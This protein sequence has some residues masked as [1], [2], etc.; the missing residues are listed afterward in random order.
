[1]NKPR[2][3]KLTDKDGKVFTLEY[4]R[5][6]AK[7]IEE[8]GLSLND[9]DDKPTTQLPLLFWGAFRMHHRNISLADADRIRD[10]ELCGLTKEMIARLCE[11]YA[12]PAA[13][14]VRSEE[15]DDEADSKNVSMTVEM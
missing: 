12:Y 3:I 7:F 13:S 1:M 14:M 11:L 9:I 6:S 5:D 15:D 8:R 2:P 4:N 10:E